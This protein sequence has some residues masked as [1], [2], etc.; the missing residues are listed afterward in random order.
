VAIL[1]DDPGKLLT[2]VRLREFLSLFAPLSS[3]AEAPPGTSPP[4]S[5]YALW[6]PGLSSPVIA[7]CQICHLQVDGP[8]HGRSNRYGK[9]HRENQLRLL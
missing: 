2:F 7:P 1:D 8:R 5:S 4:S 3:E 6:L 9:R